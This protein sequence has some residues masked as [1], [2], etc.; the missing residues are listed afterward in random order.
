MHRPLGALVIVVLTVALTAGDGVAAPLA[1]VRVTR[2]SNVVSGDIGA[3]VGGVTAQVRLERRVDAG[4][5]YRIVS[6]SPTVAVDAGDGS[7]T[8]ALPATDDLTPADARDSVVV[9]FGGPG[10][11]GTERLGNAW[12]ARA[13]ADSAPQSTGALL[14]L[15][16]GDCVAVRFVVTR[17]D[18]STASVDGALDCA[19]VCRF[20][21]PVSPELTLDDRVDAIASFDR[22]GV[23]FETVEQAGI[24]VPTCEADL[25]SG[26][27]RCGQVP[28]GSYVLV[29]RREGA[30]TVAVPATR[31]AAT[32][33]AEATFADGLRNDDAID[34]QVV[35]GAGR[36]LTTL[37]AGRVRKDIDADGPVGGAL[38]GGACSS[39][40]YLGLGQVLC[41]AGGVLPRASGGALLAGA[42]YDSRSGGMVDVR[43]PAI[44]RTIPAD[45][46]SMGPA[47]YAYADATVETL[48]GARAAS[49][50]PVRLEVRRRGDAGAPVLVVANV[51]VAAGGLVSL[52][53]GRYDARWI[54]TDGN[55]DTSSR[56]TT[57]VVQPASSGAPG[58]IG[59]P[60]PAGPAG[61]QGRPGRDALVTCTLTTRRGRKV[62]VVC[63]VRYRSS[64]ARAVSLRLSRRGVA[65]ASGRATISRR[66][67]RVALR[68]RR[69]MVPARYTLTLRDGTSTTTQR[70]DLRWE[71]GA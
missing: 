29:R 34:L 45:G 6:T 3:G 40:E 31:D 47:F 11:P 33:L 38:L 51:N 50:A 43:V 21:A 52:P 42:A 36:V 4:G 23:R 49:T 57:F 25:A 20:T 26:A 60:G 55:G 13:P 66:S 37:H 12:V 30:P 71:G 17:G 58:P 27:V 41:G 16:C 28:D 69:A 46:E 62:S 35:G 68:P 56:A 8:A 44:T 67:A 18:G 9:E 64:N 63:V 7:W 39:N 1:S 48:A 5:P 2:Y 15:S 54:L 70:I 10:A 65:Y 61:P 19:T 53:P 22:G 14:A 32:R 59:P 24:A